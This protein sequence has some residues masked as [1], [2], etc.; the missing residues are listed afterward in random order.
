M[1]QGHLMQN[2]AV[3]LLAIHHYFVIKVFM[4]DSRNSSFEK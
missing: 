3:K 4:Y 2:E 1:K